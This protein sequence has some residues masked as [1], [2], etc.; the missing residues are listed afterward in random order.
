MRASCGPVQRWTAG[1]RRTIALFAAAAVVLA[2]CSGSDDGASDGGDGD[3]GEVAA[4]EAGV[5]VAEGPAPSSW[6]GDDLVRLDQVV[7]D[8]D[9]VTLE[10]TVAARTERTFRD[11]DVRLLTNTGIE[12]PRPAEQERTIP[13]GSTA[14]LELVA[15]GVEEATRT[16]EAEVLGHAVQVELPPD[17][18]TLRFPEAPLRQVGFVDAVMRDRSPV[19]VRPYTVRS[20]GLITEVTFL[21]MALTTTNPDLCRYG[22]CYLEDSSGRT[23]PR[24][25]D[26]YEFPDGFGSQVRGTLRFLGELPPDE[27]EFQLRLGGSSGF[28]TTPDPDLELGFS[29][30]RAEDAPLKAAAGDTFPEPFDVDQAIEEEGGTVYEL[31]QLSFHEDRI[32]LEVTATAPADVERNLNYRG[33]SALVDPSGYR[34]PLTHAA[35]GGDLMVEAG[36]IEATLVFLSPLAPGVDELTLEIG[37][38]ETP[39]RTTIELPPRPDAEAGDEVTVPD[40]DEEPSAMALPPHDLAG[41]S[42]GQETDEDAGEDAGEPSVPEPTVTVALDIDGQLPAT[43]WNPRGRVATT[44]QGRGGAEA[45]TVD[46]D[47]AAEA[48]ASLEDLGAERT[49]DGLVVTLPETVLFDFDSAELVGDADEVVARV[50]EILAFYA[51]VEVEVRGH[52][53]DV[54]SDE[55][56]QEL[57]EARAS[58]VVDALVGAGASSAQ[59]TAVGR[60]ASDPIA[61][62]A[63]P[64]GDDDPEGRQQ[65]RRVEI[66]LRE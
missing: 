35:D 41:T 58:A 63:T 37:A 31:G 57:S 66:V 46:P 17:G 60:G 36:T 27:T 32:Q 39:T 5:T 40:A 24:V 64:S 50:A 45:D 25:G 4:E 54:G 12:L 11:H 7:R 13:A 28:M 65:N 14:S 20:E 43:V 51:D 22:D 47:A 53:D 55:Y 19:V 42:A 9:D 62:N 61:P 6:S 59:L 15:S 34:H 23:F 26:W 16:L 3:G 44:V 21:G 8:G 38:R 30:P 2:G 49:P 1:G 48:E 52:T 29:L 56:N 10:L 18:E 33:E